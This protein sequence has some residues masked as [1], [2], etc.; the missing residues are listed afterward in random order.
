MI[1]HDCTSRGYFSSD[2]GHDRVADI[3][4]KIDVTDLLAFRKF[5]VKYICEFTNSLERK[6]ISQL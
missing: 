6:W 4:R 2:I 3:L 1:G 5:Q